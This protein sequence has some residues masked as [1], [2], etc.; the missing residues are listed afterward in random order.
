[1]L[2][3]LAEDVPLAVVTNS[4]DALGQVA[5]AQIAIA[6]KSIITA[7]PTERLIASTLSSRL[8]GAIGT[9]SKQ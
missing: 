1:V 6:F 4:S 5:A 8:P 3:R 2:G 9:S 7:D